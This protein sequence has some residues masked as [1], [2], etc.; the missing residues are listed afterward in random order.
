MKKLILILVLVLA[1]PAFAADVVLQWDENTETD[2]A[3]Y[4][5][6]QSSVSGGPYTLV[7]EIPPNYHETDSTLPNDFDRDSYRVTS[8]A[9]GIYYWVLTA[10]DNEVPRNIS[11]YSNEVSI[12]VINNIPV[13]IPPAAPTGLTATQE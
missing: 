1:V 5:V 12:Q 2:L 7:E 10:Y 13:P 8:L 6:F 11:G 3:G 4:Q 9:D